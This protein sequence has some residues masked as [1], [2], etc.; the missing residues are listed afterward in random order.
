MT[1]KCLTHVRLD[2]DVGAGG[3]EGGGGRGVA[4][5]DGAVERDAAFEAPIHPICILQVRV[6]LLEGG[7][8][9][10]VSVR[11]AI[12]R[13]GII[14]EKRMERGVPTAP[15]GSASSCRTS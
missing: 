14:S 7:R 15:S 11:I 4:E 8:T 9:R 12:R 3:D 6:C 2:V 13:K 10:G 5:E 1:P